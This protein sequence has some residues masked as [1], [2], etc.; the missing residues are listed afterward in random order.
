MAQTPGQPIQPAQ[1]QRGPGL[2]VPWEPVLSAAVGRPNSRDIDDYIS[3]GGYDALK[4]ALETMTPQDVTKVV[5][6]SKLVGRGGAGFPTGVKWGGTAR[7]PAPRYLV[8]NADESEPGTFGN[9]YAIDADPHMLL[10]GMIICCYAVDIQQGHIY[11]RGENLHGFEVLE[12]AI[13]QAYQKGILGPSVMGKEGFGV[14]IYVTRGAGA[15]ICGEETALME[16][17]EGRRAQPRIRP[18][19]PIEVGGGLFGRPT[20]VNNVETLMNVPHIVERGAEWFAGIGNPACPGPKLYT[21]SGSVNK[22]GMY[23]LP[24]GVSLRDLIYKYAGGMQRDQKVKA[25]SPG[26]L[27]CQILPGD[28]LD[29]PMDTA[30]LTRPPYFIPPFGP[31]G[32]G[33]GGIV[34]YG[35]EVDMVQIITNIAGFFARESCG[36]CVPCREGTHWML[37]MLRRIASGAGRPK[38]LEVLRDVATNIAGRKTLCALGDFAVNPVGSGLRLFW[39]EFEA[40]VTKSSPARLLE[41]AAAG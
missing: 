11:I 20:V 17:L 38:D 18:P 28:N 37:D 4:K 39:D 30:T 14:D 33:A 3:R 21:I 31:V 13:T 7:N 19:F 36:K 6:D 32:F 35:E 15:Y 34:V 5:A 10:D 8:V 12:A 9:R 22:P 26:A 41:P 40:H 1:P 27:A 2:P 16:S 24:M 29:I 23:E 25:V